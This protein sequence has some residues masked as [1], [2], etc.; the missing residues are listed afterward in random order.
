MSAGTAVAGETVGGGGGGGLYGRR[1]GRRLASRAAAAAEAAAPRWHL[2]AAAWKRPRHGTQPEVQI[3]Y[4]PPEGFSFT[5]GEQTFT[6]PAGVTSIHVDAF[7]GNGGSAGAAGGAAAEVSGDLTVTPGQVLYV[8]VGGTGTGTGAGGFNGGGSGAGGGGGASDVRSAPRSAGLSPDD[9]LLVAGGGGGGGGNGEA[10]EGAA[11]GPAGQAGATSSGANEGGGAGT[12]SAGGIG[13]FGA[14][15]NGSPGELA[16]GGSGGNG[17][18]AVGGGGGG[19]VYGGGGGGG[20]L[21]FGAG[22]GRRRLLDGAHRRHRGNG[23]CRHPAPRPHHLHRPVPDE[24]SDERSSNSGPPRARKAAARRPRRRSPRPASRRPF[25]GRDRALAQISSKRAPVGTTFSFSLNEAATVTF[26]FVKLLPGRKVHG[27]CVA[28]SGKNR[29]KS[30]CKRSLVA[31]TLTFRAHAGV[32]KVRFAGR[33]SSAKKLALGSY[34][35]Q[36]FARNAQGVRSSQRSLSFKI[37]K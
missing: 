33:I 1:R 12:G 2:P 36:I 8:E 4:T 7:G 34:T 17:G 10:G 20:G 23:P 22:G 14:G 29:H 19:G 13:G 37:V 35:L 9:R 11:G 30:S 16:L 15:A 18:G 27:R 5:G 3:T 21:A 32:N 25:G 6:V 26:N 31:G 24:R 28:Q